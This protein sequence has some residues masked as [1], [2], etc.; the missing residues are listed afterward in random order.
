MV[1]RFDVLLNN[2]SLTSID[3]NL[4][5]KDISYPAPQIA[6][7]VTTFAGR[8][9]GIVTNK[10]KDEASVQVTFELHVYDPQKR[11]KALQ[12]IILWATDGGKLQTSDRPDQFLRCVCTQL[13]SIDSAQKWTNDLSVTFTA[14]SVPYWQAMIPEKLTLTGS[15]VSDSLYVPGNAETTA[16][17]VITASESITGLSVTFGNKTLTLDSLTVSEGESIEIGHDFNGL[18]Y[19]MQD[20]VSILNLRTA[21]SDDDLTAPCGNIG[22]SVYAD[23]EFTAEISARGVWN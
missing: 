4:Y 17:I 23:G 9:G 8:N 21:G 3:D 16:D 19:I 14:Y 20:G 12:E 1:N 2:I 22:V 18:L 6:H 5:I 10:R 13:P 7:T 11:Q 15:D